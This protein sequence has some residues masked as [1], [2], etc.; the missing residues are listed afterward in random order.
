MTTMHNK[1]RQ[2]WNDMLNVTHYA[3]HSKPDDKK[4]NKIHN[5]QSHSGKIGA[6]LC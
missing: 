3:C 2:V 4:L 5:L 6:M 1:T